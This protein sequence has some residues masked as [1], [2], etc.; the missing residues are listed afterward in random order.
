MS[1]EDTVRQ[2]K[3]K[4]DRIK[5]H[6]N[7][8]TRRLWVGNEAL[9]YGYGG[10]TLVAEA[11]QISRV[12]VT[13]GHYEVWQANEAPPVDRIRRV[14]G[15]R[16]SITETDP[17][18][19]DALEELVDPESRGDP[20]SPLRWTL[21]STRT[22]ARRLTEIGYDIKHNRVATLLRELDYSLQA[23]R[24][25]R[26]GAQHPDR[27]KQFEYINTYTR[28]Q[29]NRHNPVISVDTKKKEL[30]GSFKNNGTS[31]RPKKT[32]TEVSVHDFPSQAKG[33]AIPYGVYDVTDNSGYVSVGNDHDTAEF[34][35]NAIRGW[36]E[37][38][39]RKLYIGSSE[40]TITADGGGSNSS[41]SKLWKKTLQDFSNETG[42][43]I[44][45]LHF[46]PG[47][48]KWN[49]I[50][51]KLFSFIGVNWKGVP[52]SSYE[53]IIALIGNTT[54]NTGLKVFASLDERVYPTGITVTDEEIS[55]L[56]LM[57][58]DWHGDW[59]YTITPQE[60]LPSIV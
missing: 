9:A 13:K 38:L 26:E 44:N 54:N 14:G 12:T 24:K 34:A 46:P 11:T 32:P 16:K 31:W 18:I 27:N 45:M 21:K 39:G 17:G 15:G 33:S 8:K 40:L 48:S 6:L 58:H 29:I 43:K 20:E 3:T 4:Y 5:A 53:V 56:N 42:L 49:K 57:R 36:W 23:L 51:H 7:E 60:H 2:I 22:L 47:T 55:A 10:I 30:V 52:L 25:Q 59:N 37:H 1:R 50:E 19:I 35:V 41:R 28:I